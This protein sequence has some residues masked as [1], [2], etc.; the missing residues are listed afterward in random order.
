M[1]SA[2]ENLCVSG[3]AVDNVSEKYFQLEDVGKQLGKAVVPHIIVGE[4]VAYALPDKSKGP[5]EEGNDGEQYMRPNESSK[6]DVSEK[7][8]VP[9][10][11]V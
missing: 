2:S 4:D 11:I 8:L 3:V 9:H 6:D 10:K 5:Q 1:T 7:Y